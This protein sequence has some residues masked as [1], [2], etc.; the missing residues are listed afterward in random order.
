M[1]TPDILET[2]LTTPIRRASLLH[3]ADIP[4][5]EGVRA[6]WPDWAPP[7]L[8]AAYR[9][10]GVERPWVHQVAA[11]EA[12]HAGWHTVVATSTGSG[13]SLA[14]WLPALTAVLDAP[15]PA[16]SVASLR[17]RAGVLYLSP[18]KA[19]AADQLAALD[20]LLRAGALGSDVRAATCD[21]DTP[22]DERDW[23]RAHADIVLTNPDFLHFSLLPG[24]ERWSRLLRGLRYVV[25]DEC[26]AYRGVLGAHVALVL[27]RLLRI[28]RHLGADP[29]VVAASATTGEPRETLARLIAAGVDDVIAVT[30]DT[31]PAGR[32][33]I[34]LWEPPPLSDPGEED[35]LGLD[36]DPGDDALVGDPDDVP[37]RSALRETTELLAD[38]VAARRRSLAFVR[39][40]AGVEALAEATTET[41]AERGLLPGPQRSAGL[42][43][44]REGDDGDDAV[45]RLQGGG[46][47]PV[48]AYRGGYLPEER[49]TLEA[50]LREGRL[51]GLATTNALELG[52]DVAGLDAVLMSG[53]PG[54]RVSFWQQA[55]RA[56]RAGADG[57]AVL[58]AGANPLD[59]Y[60]VH[61]P[62]AILAEGVEATTFDPS[63]PYV[64]APHLCVAAFELPLTEA[65]LPLFG[66]ADTA[67]LTELA[68]R[69]LLRRRP[70]GW[71]WNHARPEAPQT[72]TDL[73]GGAGGQVAIVEEET[74]RVLGTV[75]GTRADAVVH[76]GAVYVH[77]G[78]TYVVE[79]LTEDAALV[80]AEE[81][82]RRTSAVSSLTA[83]IV[84]VRE[85]TLWGP[86]TWAFGEVEVSSRVQAYD[87]RHPPSPEVL[88]TVP[89]EMP[90]RTLP[91]TGVWWSAPTD[92]LCEQTGLTPGDLPGA[93]HAAEHAAI[94][95]LPLLATCDR[96]DIGGL[97]TALHPDTGAPTVVVHDGYPGGAGF[98][99]RGFRAAQA[100]IEATYGA[101]TSCGCRHGCPRCVYSPKCGN[102]N[103]PLDKGGALAVLSFLRSVAP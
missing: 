44:H 95:V 59:T 92:E 70:A 84:Q 21:G 60:L 6:D 52:I 28:A 32:R 91:T 42:E 51:L 96:W 27:R 82:G 68:D 23:V 26:H 30:S 87:V 41:L 17:R 11:A 103:H 50:A 93:L 3:V 49:R 25:L 73:R 74:G 34:A 102:G 77:Q 76:P 83:H 5:R 78:R 13:K 39:S 37:R 56:G 90:L 63:N 15:S 97:S 85:R 61:H 20:A 101:I 79:R 12:A 86:V 64:L 98:A 31:A 75:D 40:R 2:L 72:L 81:T 47:V 67:L 80:H 14:V 1:G 45:A 100:W 16:G 8:V 4:A 24:H 94:G 10:R 53:W 18:T 43:V 22:L 54:T 69:G 58:I 19:L 46:S 35:D 55:G 66:L 62:E 7:R 48:A 9:A 99:E 88:T 33:R 89:L 57:V 71:Y 36:L 65:D 29:V 38:L